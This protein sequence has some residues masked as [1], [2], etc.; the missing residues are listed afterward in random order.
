MLEPPAAQE[1]VEL[2]IA[3]TCKAGN[4]VRSVLC[5]YQP[6]IHK[7]SPP[8]DCEIVKT[9]AERL[10]AVFVHPQGPPLATEAGRA[11][12]QPYHAMRDAVRRLVLNICS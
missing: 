1:G 4:E 2:C 7:Q 3:G 6:G 11:L 10:S 8:L 5:R 12:L 9:A